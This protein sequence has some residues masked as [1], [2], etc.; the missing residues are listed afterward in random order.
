MPK[1]S[2]QWP[3]RLVVVHIP[4]TAGSWLNAQLRP[5]YQSSAVCPFATQADLPHNVDDLD[6]YQFMSIN[7]G[8]EYARKIDAKLVTVLREPRDRLIS[9]YHYWRE[10]PEA[11]GGPGLAKRYD[12]EGFIDAAQAEVCIENIVDAQMWQLAASHLS[13]ARE[14]YVQFTRLAMLQRAMSNLNKFAVVGIREDLS[15]LADD[16]R[17]RLNISIDPQSPPE[18]VTRRRPRFADLPRSTLRKLNSV[19]EFDQ[20]LYSYVQNQISDLN[21]RGCIRASVRP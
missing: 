21:A 18:N 20:Q 12:L 6:K 19:T 2:Q 4:K 17:Q 10:D 11:I 8:F 16:L 15:A 14:R 3:P 13:H 5:L 1:T 7:V 9:L